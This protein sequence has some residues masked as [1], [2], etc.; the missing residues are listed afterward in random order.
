MG[1]SNYYISLDKD[2]KD[3]CPIEKIE[4]FVNH[5]NYYYEKFSEEELKKLEE[6]DELPGED[7][8][9]RVLTQNVNGKKVYWAY[10]G[11]HGG[12]GHTYEWLSTYFPNIKMFNSASWEFYGEEWNKWPIMEV[13]DYKKLVNKD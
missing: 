6:T 4:E 10:L 11:N 9:L 8:E 7:L 5:H 3:Y 13:E 1:W 2:S 12:Y